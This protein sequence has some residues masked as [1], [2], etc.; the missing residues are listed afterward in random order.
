M[1]GMTEVSPSA[2]SNSANGGKVGRSTPPGC[3]PKASRSI[4]TCATKCRCRYITPLGTPVE[5][6]VN[7]I[8]ATSSGRVSAS[9]GPAPA[10]SRSTC[11]SVA[12]ASQA[13]VPVVTRAR[14]ERAQPSSAFASNASGMPMKASACASSRHCRSARLSMPGST[15]TGTA[16][17][18][19]SANITRKNS[20]VGR[21]ITTVR[22]PRTMPRRARP[23]A[24]ASLRA[25]SCA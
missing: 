25:S 7:R 18:L 1:S 11:A 4:S 6:L 10:P 12:S 13:R 9:R 2:G 24:M 17:A 20:G 14:A 15:S 22:V 3:M 21:T 19:N 8:A 23:A 5:P 16:P